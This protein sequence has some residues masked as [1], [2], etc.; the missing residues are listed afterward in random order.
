MKNLYKPLSLLLVLALVGCNDDGE[1]EISDLISKIVAFDVGNEQSGNDIRIGF[2]LTA[3]ELTEFWIVVNRDESQLSIGAIK[4]LADDQV[5]QAS[6][7]QNEAR[8]I[9]LSSVTKDTDGAAL[10][11]NQVYTLQ[12]YTPQNNKVTIPSDPFTLQDAGIYDGDYVGTWSDNLYTNFGISAQLVSSGNLV[13]GAFF[14]SNNFTSCCN[15]SND[16]GISFT[17][18]GS[19]VLDFKYNQQIANFVGVSGQTFGNC[20]GQYFGEGTIA[21]DILLD[22]SYEG[23][24]CE[25][26]HTGG[27]IRLRRVN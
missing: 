6:V 13:R 20:P 27:K 22:I 7:D 26:P 11:N 8:S 17:I 25:G 12:I 23:E 10:R 24:D 19:Q 4:A 3:P 15:G 21:N 2:D 5:H 18:D 9:K 16:G 1:D 14:Y